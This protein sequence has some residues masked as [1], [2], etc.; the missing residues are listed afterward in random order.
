MNQSS[1]FL[2]VIFEHLGLTRFH[3]THKEISSRGKW[4]QSP[5]R[6]FDCLSPSF[7]S[8]SLKKC[9]LPSLQHFK[10][11]SFPNCL[12]KNPTWPFDP[13]SLMTFLQ[14]FVLYLSIQSA[15]F[16]FLETLLR[17]VEDLRESQLKLSNSLYPCLFCFVL[18]MINTTVHSSGPDASLTGFRF[19]GVPQEVF[20]LLPCLVGPQFFH[21]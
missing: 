16:H 20:P 3:Q 7:L 10:S 13:V 21:K 19:D 5:H 1:L 11:T 8:A 4:N 15:C 14:Y 18:L 2:N 6:R 9:H 17:P 12:Q